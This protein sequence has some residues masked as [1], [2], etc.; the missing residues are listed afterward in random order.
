MCGRRRT[1]VLPLAAVAA[2]ALAAPSAAAAGGPVAPWLNERPVKASAHPPLAAPCR[3]G[4]LHAQL[5]L[6]GATGSLVGGVDLRNAGT[7]A[8]SLLGLPTASFAGGGATT[9]RWQVKSLPA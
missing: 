7:R 9:E 8:C 3:A 6:Q 1:T 4:D 5:F 2:F